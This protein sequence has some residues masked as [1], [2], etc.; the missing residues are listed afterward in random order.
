MKYFSDCHFH[1]MTMNEPNFISFVNSFYDSAT[2][3]LFSNAASDYIITPQMMKGDKF[4]NT[5]TNAL[6]AF[7]RP[8]GETLALMEDDLEGIYTSP[9]K[10]EYA[11]LLPYIH[12]GRFHI[13]SMEAERLLMIPL[14]MDFSQDKRSM[15]NVYY[16]LP[17]ENKIT[18]YIE[19][20]IEG[21]REYGR[22][23]PD[24]LFEFYPFM[25]IEPSVH[26]MQFMEELISRYVNTSHHFHEAGEIPDRPC[27][28]IKVYPP[29]G[30]KP[31]PN[32]SE[33]LGKHRYLYSF[34]ERNGIPIITHADDQGFRGV[35]AEEAWE[36]TDPAAWRTVLENYPSLTIDFAHFGRQYAIASRSNVQSLAARLRHQP[37]SPWFYSIISL[38]MDFE[39]VYAD[40]SFSGSTPEFYQELI[41]FLNDQTSGKRARILNRILFGSDF[42]VNLL[43]VE[44]YTEYFSIF[45][46]SRFTD[47]E[48]ENIGEKNVLRFLDLS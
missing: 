20:T 22:R 48:I 7:S 45:E 11:P 32:D 17:A 39:N 29:L 42:A 14:L 37:D 8:I 46:H 6:S 44:S 15:E 24:G 3:L 5:L 43:K 40:L 34:C 35:S 36:N 23:H 41:A 21:F 12:D 47:E 1:V 33:T 30:F 13:R 38:M 2:G 9:R 26:S 4:L 28:G 19:A 27:Y 18:P 31:W 16:N 25:G 10:H